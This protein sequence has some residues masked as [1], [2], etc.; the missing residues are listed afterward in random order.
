MKFSGKTYAEIDLAPFKNGIETGFTFDVF[1]KVNNTG[2][3]N[4]KVV[5]CK[6]MST[7]YQGFMLDTEK[8]LLE[9]KQSVKH[10]SKRIL[11]LELHLL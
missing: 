1:F 11:G 10:N 6:N 4:A 7:P 8:A 3:M 5:N 2:N 9:G